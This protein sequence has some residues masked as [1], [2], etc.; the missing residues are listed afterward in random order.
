M[1]ILVSPEINW[2]KFKSLELTLNSDS[3][4]LNVYASVLHAI[5]LLSDGHPWLKLLSLDSNAAVN[6][7]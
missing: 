5:Y 2:P 7:I 6:W 1:N 4:L 3:I